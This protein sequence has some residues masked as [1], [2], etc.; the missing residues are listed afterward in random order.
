M[1]SLP[2][3]GALPLL[4]SSSI[5][6]GCISFDHL[7]GEGEQHIR[8]SAAERFGGLEVDDQFEFGRLFDRKVS[9]FFPLKNP[10]DVSRRALRDG[11]KVWPV[12]HEPAGLWKGP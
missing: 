3:M 2:A 10:V 6:Y 8:Y 5:E 4:R 1:V 12:G 7:V 11:V 9:R